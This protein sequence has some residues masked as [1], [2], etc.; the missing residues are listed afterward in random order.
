MGTKSRILKALFNMRR[1]PRDSACLSLNE[2][3]S[4]VVDTL[5]YIMN[6]HTENN[7]T[8]HEAKELVNKISSLETTIMSVVWGFLL[9]RLNTTSSDGHN[10]IIRITN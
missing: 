10:R 6:D 3:W 1:S 8:R 4:T 9:S 7:I 5:T 2:N